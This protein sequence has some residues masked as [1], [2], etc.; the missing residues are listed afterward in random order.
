MN[1]IEKQAIL[2]LCEEARGSNGGHY[3]YGG[4]VRLAQA[5]EIMVKSSPKPKKREPKADLKMAR[6]GKRL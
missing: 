2:K 5:I 3:E 6:K 4:I 1:R